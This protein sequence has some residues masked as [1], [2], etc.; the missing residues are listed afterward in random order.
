MDAQDGIDNG[1]SRPSRR[2]LDLFR[3]ISVKPDGRRIQSTHWCVRFQHQGKRTCRTLGTPDYRLANQRARQLVASIRQNGWARATA[4]P[5]S[6]G[7]VSIDDL[8]D[9]YHRAAVSRDLRPRSIGHAQ[10][11][12]RRVARETGARRLADLSPAALQG[13]IQSCELKPITLRSVL[14][15]A[16]TVFSRLSLQSMGM[17]DLQNPFARLAL[18]K[19]DRQ[20]FRSPSR[21]WIVGLMQQGLKDLTGDARRAF[22]L[23]L[24]AGLRWGEIGS[25][26]WDDVRSDSV[27]IAAAKAKGRRARVVPI[28]EPV[29]RA[30]EPAHAEGPVLTQ[31]MKEVHAA[32]CAWLKR[33]GVKDSKPVHYLRKCFGSLA[34]GD[35]GIY[36]ASKLLGHA[37]I[38]LTAS[39]YAGQVDNLPAVKF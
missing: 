33:Q 36:V 6:H 24:G 16:A 29:W 21:T 28:S 10:K 32:L 3:P 37:N 8:L 27:H 30:L 2:R 15:N 38:T 39:T 7:S 11:D 20:P 35:H 18:P 26:N 9:Q 1:N 19:V 22:A 23:A 4:L 34:V 13:W 17:T 14:K 12:L 31:N 5:T 25:L